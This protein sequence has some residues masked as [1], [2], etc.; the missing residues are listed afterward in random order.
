MTTRHNVLF[1]FAL[2]LLLAPLGCSDSDDGPTG[3]NVPTADDP[4]LQLI[5]AEGPEMAR[6][7]VAALPDVVGGALGKSIDDAYYDQSCGC[8]RWSVMEENQTISPY[9]SRSA[10]FSATFYAGESAQMSPEGADRIALSLTFMY[11]WAEFSETTYKNREVLFTLD[12]EATDWDS[13]AMSVSGTGWGE[14][15]GGEGNYTDEEYDGFYEEFDIVHGMTLPLSGCPTGS[16][17][18]ATEEAGF[19]MDFDGTPTAAWA[20]LF[21]GATVDSG[22]FPLGCGTR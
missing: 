9:W 15:F 10:A 20:Y 6:A 11:T 21:G 3:P 14:V 2:I 13:G 1:C 12:C 8:W 19:T 7:I 18:L 4:A 17:D 16:I 22:T 5:Q